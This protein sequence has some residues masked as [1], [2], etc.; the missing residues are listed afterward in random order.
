MGFNSAFKG[1]KLLKNPGNGRLNDFNDLVLKKQSPTVSVYPL[2]Y[3]IWT[4]EMFFEDTKFSF[5]TS[6]LW[7]L[8]N[9]FHF[10]QWI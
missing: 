3:A 1:L 6:I 10:I 2:G 5:S 7:T 9:I 8:R 4:V